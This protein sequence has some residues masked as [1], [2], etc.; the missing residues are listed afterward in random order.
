MNSQ[1][2]QGILIL[3]LGLGMVL[4]GSLALAV[5]GTPDLNET[6]ILAQNGDTDAQYLLGGIYRTGQGAGK[7]SKRAAFWFLRAAM[8]G[9]ADAQYQLGRIHETGDGVAQDYTQALAWYGKAAEQGHPEAQSHQEKIMDYIDLVKHSASKGEVDAQCTLGDMYTKG[10]GVPHDE[11]QAATW[12]RQAAEQGSARGQFSLG[13]MYAEGKGV[14][15]DNHQAVAWYA[16]AAAQGYADAEY[17]LSTM[18]YKGKGVPPE[19]VTAYAW[20]SLA[21]TQGHAIA[22]ANKAFAASRLTP[23][24]MQQAQ[25]LSKKLEAKIAEQ[26]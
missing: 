4:S 7:D 16:K 23:S 10:S 1:R 11:E 24:Q 21:A 6:L 25:L 8:G 3:L 18:Y 5:D 17:H 22:T 15:L 19:P 9:H 14:P 13:F 12:Y 20:L 26:R 2:L